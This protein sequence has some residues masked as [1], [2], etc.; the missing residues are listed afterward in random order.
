MF[1]S[2]IYYNNLSDFKIKKKKEFK[3]E[4]DA[5]FCPPAV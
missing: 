4:S 3:Q 2:P 1:D 5:S